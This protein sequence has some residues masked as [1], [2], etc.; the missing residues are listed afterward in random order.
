MWSRLDF[1]PT[2]AYQWAE[3]MAWKWDYNS[4]VNNL[5][6]Q[7]QVACGMQISEKLTC[8]SNS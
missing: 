8:I 4:D 6:K 2:Y 3:T 7:H 5:V 1:L